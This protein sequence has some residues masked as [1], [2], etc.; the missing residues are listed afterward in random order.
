MGTDDGTIWYQIL[1][2]GVIGK[3]SEHFLPNPFVTPAGKAFVDAIPVT[4]SL[5]QLTPL[6]ASARDC[7]PMLPVYTGRLVGCYHRAFAQIRWQT[8]N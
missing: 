2:I 3:M 8:L 7:V 6:R 5:W 1:H 4:I